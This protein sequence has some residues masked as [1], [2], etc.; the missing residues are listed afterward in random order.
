MKSI[1]VLAGGAGS[2]MGCDKASLMLSGKTL[3]EHVVE[4][5]HGLTEELIVVSNKSVESDGLKGRNIVW[6]KD[7]IE[8]CGPMGGI[9]AGL[10]K[11]GSDVNLVLGCD[12][13]FVNRELAEF[14]LGLEGF[15]AVV[16]RINGRLQPLHALYSKRC[17]P[18]IEDLLADGRLRV[19]DIFPRVEVRYL[20]EVELRRFHD[21][22]CFFNINDAGDLMKAELMLGEKGC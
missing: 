22:Y 15:D 18:V 16:P 17:L 13:P 4:K 14:L 20:S 10:V 12:M 1:I 21:K 7:L 6:T 9:H 8:G 3:L 19:A 5:V 11:S 2:R